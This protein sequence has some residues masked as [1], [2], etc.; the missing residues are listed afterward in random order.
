MINCLHIAVMLLRQWARTH[1]GLFSPV[2]S[3]VGR[4]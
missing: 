1:N 4:C 3:A 2:Q